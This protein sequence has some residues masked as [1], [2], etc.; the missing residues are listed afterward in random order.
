MIDISKVSAQY[1]KGVG[2]DRANLLKRLGIMSIR[3]CF[4]HFPKRYEDR[5]KLITIAEIAAPRKLCSEQELY[6]ISDNEGYYTIKGVV[7]SSGLFR[8]RTRTTILQ[9]MVSDGTGKIKALWFNQPYLKD[10]FV[11]GQELYLYGNFQSSSRG[12]QIIHPEYEF[13]SEEKTEDDIIHTARIVP[14]YPLVSGI[15]QRRL[16]NII[17]KCISQY[18]SNVQDYLPTNIR[19]RQRL[20][21]LR[22]AIKNIHFPYNERQ[23]DEARRRLVF[24]EFF[25]LQ[26]ALAIKRYNAKYRALGISNKISEDFDK[27]FFS[28]LPFKLTDS[29]VNVIEDIKKDMASPNSM[30]RLVQGE[31][32]SGKTMICAYALYLSSRNNYQS[33]LMVPTEI[34]AR[35]HYI[36]LTNIFSPM[37]ISTGLLINGMPKKEKDSI[38]KTAASGEIDVLVG[39]HSLIQ[40]SADFKNLGLVVMDEQHKFGVEQRALLKSKSKRADVLVMSA[41]PIPRTMAMTLYGDM[42]ISVV[43]ALPHGKRD[44]RTL[45]LE[46]SQ[47]D[48]AYEFVKEQVSFGQQAYIVYPVIDESES[49]RSDGAVKM[50]DVLSNGIFKDFKVGLLHGRMTDDEK[51]YVMN[52]FKKGDVNILIATTIVEVGVDVSNATVMIIEGAERFGL[53][54]LHQLRGR[55]GRER[56]SS[57]CV[58]ISDADTDEARQRLEIL[59][60]TDEGAKIAEE[61]L[62]IRGPGELFGR[63]QH[64]FPELRIANLVSDVDVLKDAR[65]E[66][67]ALIE[68]DPLLKRSSH[69]A[70]RQLLVEQFKDKF[71]LGMIG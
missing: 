46:K 10:Y 4:W 69:S 20:L 40:R 15:N 67:F 51:V 23:K 12:I 48:K 66:A 50:F 5:S 58:L 3:D 41:T 9:V 27:E 39:T 43:G 11:T 54:Q 65:K 33:A 19:A 59:S 14:I 17:K 2:P 28:N 49:L 55:I 7:V 62:S 18:V 64:G 37:G 38:L 70:I 24:D 36:T 53:S 16:R 30:H 52:N 35:Q 57:Y 63:R 21:D 44:V 47:R 42:D 13:I 26:L 8:G 56:K 6:S 61:D 60:R 32:G 34:L 1:I 68:I 29:Q 71:Y 45:W 25:I 31:V 22:S